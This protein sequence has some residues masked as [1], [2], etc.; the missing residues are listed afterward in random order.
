MTDEEIYR[1]YRIWEEYRWR[2]QDFNREMERWFETNF[3][4]RSGK[5]SG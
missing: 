1:C 5:P 2:R 4:G 3:L